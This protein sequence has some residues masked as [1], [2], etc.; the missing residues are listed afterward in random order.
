M[1]F[2]GAALSAT[3]RVRIAD[4]GAVDHRV[5]GFS[6]TSSDQLV[7]DSSNAVQQTIK[8]IGTRTTGAVCT[9][10]TTSGTDVWIEGVRVDSTGKLVIADAAPQTYTSGNPIR[11]TGALATTTV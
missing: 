11:T 8:G 3:D 2:T 10:T 9:T 6:F 5:A 4:G 7:T 1:L